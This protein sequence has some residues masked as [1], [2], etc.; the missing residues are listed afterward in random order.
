MKKSEHSN[1]KVIVTIFLLMVC[2]GLF[3]SMTSLPVVTKTKPV[4]EASEGKS[5]PAGKYETTDAVRAKEK[6]CLSC[7]E[8]IEVINE[9]MQEFLLKEAGG[10]NGY[11]CAV[12][13]EGVPDAV[14]KAEGH[15]GMYPNPSSMWVINDGNGCAKCHSN[16]EAMTTLMGKP[17][18]EPTGGGIRSVISTVSDPSGET[19]QNHVY[20]ME[21]ALMALETGK[22]NKTLM[23]NGVIPKGQWKYA[24]FDMDDPDGFVP[25]VGSNEYKEWIAK[26]LDTK[27]I[28]AMDHTERIPN[29]EEGTKLWGDPAK[30][31]FADMHRKQ[32]GRCHVWGE[33]R[34]KRGD[35]R[36]GGCAACHVL[37]TNDGLSESGDPTLAKDTPAHP[38]KHKITTSIPTQQCNHCHTR[39][40]RI[41]TTFG[42]IIEHQYV[43]SG[44]T[45]PFDEKGNVQSPL[46]TKEYNHVREDVHGERGMM[47][48]DCHSSIDVHGDGNIYPVTF[49]QVEVGC[50]DC[51]GTPKKYPWELPVG[52][53]TPIETK[54]ERGFYRANEK[55]HLITTR[56]NPRTRWIKEGDKAY[57][58]NVVDGKRREMPLLKNVSL[59]N[60]WKTEQGRVAMGVI[61]QH[62]E[63]MECYACHST[64]APQCF[65]C[66]IKYDARKEGIDWPLSAE[67]HTVMGK[68]VITKAAG[69]IHTENVSYIRWENPLLVMNYKGRVAPA[70]P[71]CQTVWTFVDSN[72]VTRE[73]NKIYKTSDGNNSPT[74]APLQPHANTAVARTCESCHTDPKAIGYGA[75]VSRSSSKIDKDKPHFANMG[76]DTNADIPWSEKIKPQIPGI[77]GFPYAWDQ[78]VTRSGIQTQ[79]LPLLADRP[80][81]TE[82]RNKVEREGACVGCHKFYNTPTWDA[83]SVNTLKSMT[84]VP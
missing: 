22:A 35:H 16:T 1:G 36:A 8:G 52:Y 61:S 2:I 37:Y 11:E 72:G 56:G 79:N 46:Y 57:L 38:M 19:G 65:G 33:G 45:P 58:I 49:Y 9:K 39:G 31:G 60:K 48:A 69:D 25:S 24:N 62:N 47:C 70:M 3:W 67:K 66:H 13:H 28:A 17:K 21:R 78:L 84:D 32:C 54:K 44:Q 26:A 83:T 30:A 82:E 77:P 41:G 76:V 20:R 34:S 74:I 18:K 29:L 51:H 15:K 14:T 68:Q 55:E 43:G 64:W 7:H 12:C 10:K 23:S 4:A 71:G 75:G 5:N 6:G 27:F 81:N 80:L 50:A 59:G 40:K 73:V 42:G 63:K 53:G